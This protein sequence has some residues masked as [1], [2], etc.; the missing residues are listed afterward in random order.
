MPDRPPDGPLQGR[1]CPAGLPV[2]WLSPRCPPP[3]RD[4]V[5]AGGSPSKAAGQC[6]PQ[7]HTVLGKGRGHAES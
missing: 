3:P 1:A 7:V 6:P 5:M 2:R 4:A